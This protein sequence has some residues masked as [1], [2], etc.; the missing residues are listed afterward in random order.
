MKYT[1]YQ[2]GDTITLDG[3]KDHLR[4]ADNYDA[5]QL[6]K[7]LKSATIFVQEYFN[8]A[9]VACSVLQ[10]QPHADKCFSLFLS[11]QYNIQ[12]EDYN[13]VAVSFTREGDYIVLPHREAV[14][15]SYDCQPDDVEHY[16]TIVYQIAAANY[17]GQPEMIKQILKNYPVC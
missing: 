17:D 5:E 13:G 15:I 7:L 6:S 4:I 3:L 8:V 9:L 1:K 16:A 2:Q 14:K 10:E 11:D 12:V